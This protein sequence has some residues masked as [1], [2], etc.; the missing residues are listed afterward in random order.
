MICFA[1]Y[2]EEKGRRV[3]TL[4]IMWQ[5]AVPSIVVS[6]ACAIWYDE[7]SPVRT[8]LIFSWFLLGQYV[9]LEQLK[10]MVMTVMMIAIVVSPKVANL[11]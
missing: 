10:D 1:V 8:L 6:I 7:F 2:E 4:K 5:W 11:F 3:G 9:S